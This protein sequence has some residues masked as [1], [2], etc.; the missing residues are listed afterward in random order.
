MS[1]PTL[2]R[3]ENPQVRPPEKKKYVY[4]PLNVAEVTR[5][6]SSQIRPEDYLPVPEEIVKFVSMEEVRVGV[7]L[8]PEARQKLYSELALQF[9]HTGQELLVWH[10][11]SGGIVLAAGDDVDPLFDQLTKEQKAIIPFAYPSPLML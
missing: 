8:L 4:H 11:P 7:Q 10:T 5:I 6:L 9:H 2:T 1:S 3:S